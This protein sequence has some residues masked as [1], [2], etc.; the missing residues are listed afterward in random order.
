MLLKV[1]SIVLLVLAVLLLILSMV[2]VNGDLS[3]KMKALN[4]AE[5]KDALETALKDRAPD[6]VVLQSNAVI[7]VIVSILLLLLENNGAFRLTL[8]SEPIIIVVPLFL[9]IFGVLSLISGTNAQL[10]RDQRG[11]IQVLKRLKD[12][13]DRVDPEDENTRG[14]TTAAAVVGSISYGICALLGAQLFACA[15]GLK[16]SKK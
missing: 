15:L 16:M 3:K 5:D 12:F 13:K 6:G 2:S 10:P 7:L 1:Q 8:K 14:S 4:A 9:V 11:T